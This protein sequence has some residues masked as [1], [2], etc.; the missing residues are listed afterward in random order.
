MST[1]ASIN[2][3]VACGYACYLLLYMWYYY[4]FW[5]TTFFMWW[6]SFSVDPKT[7][8]QAGKFALILLKSSWLAEDSDEPL[9]CILFGYIISVSKFSEYI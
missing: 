4:L 7:G 5:F 8:P 9:T 6:Q 3:G 1:D 2:N